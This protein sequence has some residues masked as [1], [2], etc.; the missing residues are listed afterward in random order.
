MKRAFTLMEILVS[1]MLI[2]IVLLGIAKIESQNIGVAHYLSNRI[3]SEFANSLFLGS[4]ISNY[5]KE[6]L[7]AYDALKDFNIDNLDTKRVLK[8]IDRVVTTQ[9][10]IPIEELPISVNL[11]AIMLKGDFSAIYYKIT[12]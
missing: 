8:N 11:N 12:P 3:E 4:K 1:V 10:Q 2:S 5:N 6:K 9:N 7:T